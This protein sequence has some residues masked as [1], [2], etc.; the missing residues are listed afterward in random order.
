MS[1]EPQYFDLIA[2]F[3][4]DVQSEKKQWLHHSCGGNLQIGNN[5]SIRCD[6]CPK[7]Q[8]ALSWFITEPYQ[9]SDNPREAKEMD[10]SSV[11]SLAGQIAGQAGKSWLSSFLTHVESD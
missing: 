8:P 4:E 3:P 5:A 2:S 6:K 1:T 7:E 11:A 10:F 9:L